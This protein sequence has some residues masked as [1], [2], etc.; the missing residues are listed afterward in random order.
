M[1]KII[2]L[3]LLLSLTVTSQVS[4]DRLKT[5]S[6]GWINRVV[7]TNA[8]MDS[9]FSS[10]W[11][12]TGNAIN[13]NTN[14]IGTTNNT[15]LL[16]KTNSVQRMKIDSTL[17]HV[18]IGT[19]NPVAATLRI[20]ATHG[21]GGTGT[22]IFL[23][24][25]INDDVTTAW[26]SMVIQ[27]S[28]STALS[29]GYYIGISNTSPALGSSTLSSLTYYDTG[30]QQ[31]GVTGNQYGYYSRLVSGSN[32]W[33]FYSHG[34]APSY[35]QTTAIGSSS[36]VPS[37]TLHVNGTMSVSGTATVAGALIV[38]NGIVGT[39][40][41]NF[42]SSTGF[43][44]VLQAN[45]IYPISATDLRIETRAGTTQD[46]IFRSTGTTPTETMRLL[47]TGQ[48][49]ITGNL[50][51]GNTATLTGG[52]SGTIAVLSD[53]LGSMYFQHTGTSTLNDGASVYFGNIPIS[54]AGSATTAT[55]LIPYNCTIIGYT[56]NNYTAGTLGSAE[57][58]TLSVQ[59]NDAIGIATDFLLSNVVRYD[60]TEN[61]YSSSALSY[62]LDAGDY[63]NIKLQT[64][65]FATNPVNVYGGLT[66]MYVRRK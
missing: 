53:V 66:L 6:Y 35:F 58:C 24:G 56:F 11:M 32:I 39:G 36:F 51:V 14:F 28:Y 65:T 20:N 26:R 16:F 48:T 19:A 18:S 25:T 1:K 60:A 45:H 2:L 31:S 50:S 47:S 41:M 40:N 37:A 38:S 55:V 9:T 10:F 17:G 44:N 23:Q 12:P 30:L 46:I 13:T 43:F 4:K 61:G 54:L 29:R 59:Q 49:S 52:N 34:T 21:G 5:P 62:D 63:I 15:S 57:N 27:P 8:Y 3:L 64:P 42:S 7:P 33:N 22:G